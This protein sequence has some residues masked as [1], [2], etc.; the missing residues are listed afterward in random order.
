[1]QIII[2]GNDATPPAVKKDG[3]T[4]D[5]WDGD[6][7]NITDHRILTAQWIPIPPDQ[8]TVEFKLAD[9]TQTC[10]VDLIQIIIDGNDATPPAVIK[11]GYT[12]DGWDGDYKNIIG[13]RI[14]TVQWNPIPPDSFVITFN[15][16]GGAFVNPNRDRIRV[17]VSGN[18]SGILPRATPLMF[19]RNGYRFTGWFEDI[20]DESTRWRDNEEVTG[21]VTLYA[22]WT[23]IPD[24]DNFHVGDADGDG[25][26]TSADVTRLAMYLIGHNVDICLLSADI[27]GRGYLSI[28]DVT[29]F[30]KWLVG[31]NVSPLIA[32]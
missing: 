23:Q 24:P 28:A 18:R 29:L 8:W 20:E 4:F 17:I 6:Y 7:K 1:I 2:D 19:S 26:V 11:D 25:R 21:D 16:N 9:G 13:H 3:Y 5:G 14:L 32:H 12:F 30:A 22:R 10:D 15:P 31:L 27:G